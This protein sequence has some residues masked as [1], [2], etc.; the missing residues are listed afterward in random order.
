[1]TLERKAK[2]RNKAYFRSMIAISM[3]TVWSAM[4]MTGFLLY[5]A[6]TGPRSGRL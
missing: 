2:A 3:I 1:M 6:P 5:I 4:I